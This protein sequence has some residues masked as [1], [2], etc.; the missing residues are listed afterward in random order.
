MQSSEYLRRKMQC[1]P[2]IL[3]APKPLDSGTYIWAKQ[4]TP[5]CTTSPTIYPIVI[6]SCQTAFDD[7]PTIIPAANY[8]NKCPPKFGAPPTL[9]NSKCNSCS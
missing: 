8:T 4:R 7:I 6:P 1:M 2:K 9:A 5:C 3:G